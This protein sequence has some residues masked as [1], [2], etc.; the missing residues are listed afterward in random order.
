MAGSTLVIDPPERSLYDKCWLYNL[1]QTTETRDV[2]ALVTDQNH[3]NTLMDKVNFQFQKGTPLKQG[4]HL[5][6]NFDLASAMRQQ[7]QHKSANSKRKHHN[8]H[9][10]F[11]RH[12]S[13][14]LKRSG[15]TSGSFLEPNSS[16]RRG[17]TFSGHVT[18][19]SSR[20]LVSLDIDDGNSPKN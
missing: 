16:M 15:T 6:K 9:N 8:K 4:Q 5:D 10:N 1:I 11:E 2:N 13:K 20:N 3:M 19:M 12:N 7:N 17:T 18:K 14:I